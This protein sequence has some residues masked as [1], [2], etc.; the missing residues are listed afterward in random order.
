M[1]RATLSIVASSSFSS[2]RNTMRS[3]SAF[4]NSSPGGAAT[5]C[6]PGPPFVQP[7]NVLGSTS[8]AFANRNR[9]QMLGSMVPRSMRP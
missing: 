1:T 9:E 6:Y 3:A 8:R 2:F 4:S 5:T 7:S